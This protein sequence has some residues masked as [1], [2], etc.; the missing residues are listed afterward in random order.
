MAFE[1]LYASQE[2]PL[3]LPGQIIPAF[4]LPAPDGRAYSPWDYKQ[5][6]HLLLVFIEDPQRSEARALLW[7]FASHYQAWREEQCA[8]LT[9]TA[10]SVLINK[11][12]QDSLQLPFP[13]LADPAGHVSRRYIPMDQQQRTPCIILADRYGALYQ[14]WIAH[15]EQELPDLADLL[16]SLRYLNS[17]CTP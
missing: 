6:E 4:S 16:A 5:R 12:A 3:L 11:E 8:L 15:H 2:S 10:M 13:L 14:Q 7:A 9:I 1:H 17:L